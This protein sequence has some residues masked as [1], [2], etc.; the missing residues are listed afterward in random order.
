MNHHTLNFIKL[1][2]GQ[3]M[4][5]RVPVLKQEKSPSICAEFLILH[6][7][8]LRNSQAHFSLL[9]VGHREYKYVFTSSYGLC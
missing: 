3:F 6:A 8:N 4:F 1:G 9:V 7:Q 2:Y 5:N